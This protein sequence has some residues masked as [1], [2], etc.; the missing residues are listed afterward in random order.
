MF[1]VVPD[2]DRKLAYRYPPPPGMLSG[3]PRTVCD[4]PQDAFSP[5]PSRERAEIARAAAQHGFLVHEKRSAEHCDK[6]GPAFIRHLSK[7]LL[8]NVSATLPQQERHGC[9]FD[10]VEA[11]LVG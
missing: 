1:G 6:P 5:H 7:G 3:L 8:H 10:I 4:V 11:N 9:A 2:D